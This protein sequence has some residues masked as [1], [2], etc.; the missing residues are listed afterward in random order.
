MCCGRNNGQLRSGL[1]GAQPARPAVSTRPAV[2]LQS[3]GMTF[4]YTG[5]TRLVVTGPAT[6]RQYRFDGPGVRLQV[7]PRDRAAVAAVPMLKRVGVM[8]PPR[9]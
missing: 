6:G 7:D 4:E 1:A 9:G 3:A 8:I 5:R 2:P